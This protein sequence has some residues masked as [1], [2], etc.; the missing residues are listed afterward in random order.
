[1]SARLS[2]GFVIMFALAE[3]PLATELV[4]SAEKART[5]VVA[6]PTSVFYDD[7]GAAPTLV[8]FAVLQAGGRDRGG[9]AAAG[10][11]RGE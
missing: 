10:P 8:R 7:A 9:R 5:G 4:K 3:L 1:M 6:I 2:V 11:A